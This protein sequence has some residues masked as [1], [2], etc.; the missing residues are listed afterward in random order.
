[1]R[2]YFILP[3]TAVIK[4]N[5]PNRQTVTSS[6]KAVEKLGPSY[7]A[8]RMYVLRCSGMSNSLWPQGLKRSRLHLFMEF[9]R[10]EYW[11]R[12]LFPTPVNLPKPGIEPYLSCLL[13]W[14]ADSLPL[15][16]SGKSGGMYNGAFHLKNN[17]AVPQR[18]IFRVT[19]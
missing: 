3:R 12:L 7:T 13:H 15:V 19:I 6:G 2:Q 10:Q 18:V 9:S 16:L 1:M 11:S 17:L 14:Q 5:K 8:G 4:T